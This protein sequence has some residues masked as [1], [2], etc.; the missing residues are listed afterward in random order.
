MLLNS[1]GSNLYLK[2]SQQ[3]FDYVQLMQ[4]INTP[5]IKVSTTYESN[6][7]NILSIMVKHNML[8][9]TQ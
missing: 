8:T 6:Q 3:F 2:L 4:S 7:S 5:V 1:I 9:E